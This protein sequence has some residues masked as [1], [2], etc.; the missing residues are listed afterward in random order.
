MEHWNIVIINWRKYG[1][2]V[3]L[4]RTGCLSKID[5]KMTRKLV[6]EAAK[7]PPATLK[8][9]QELLAVWYT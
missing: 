9:L 8:E 3:R 2:T 5:D 7:R 4:P 1:T 6:R